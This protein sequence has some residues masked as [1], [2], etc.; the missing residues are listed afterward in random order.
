MGYGSIVVEA[1]QPAGSEM[2]DGYWGLAARPVATESG[3][4]I[5]VQRPCPL[6]RN[7]EPLRSWSCSGD[8]RYKSVA[9]KPLMNNYRL[10]QLSPVNGFVT[11]LEPSPWTESDERLSLTMFC[12][13]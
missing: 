7:R 1:A 9:V 4:H 2:C 3:D 5:E 12:G 13:D 11:V 10:S 8:A 6:H